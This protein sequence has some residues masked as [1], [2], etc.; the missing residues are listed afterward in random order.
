M[1][2]KSILLGVAFVA[3]GFVTT[4]AIIYG[5]CSAAHSL[6]LYGVIA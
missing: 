5:V 2:W 4:S 3:A 6:G 1:D